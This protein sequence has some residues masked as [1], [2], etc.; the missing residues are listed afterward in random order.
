MPAKSI[1]QQNFMGM[2]LAAKRGATPASPRVAAAA[3]GM[4][5]TQ[6]REFAATKTKGLPGHAVLSALKNRLKKKAKK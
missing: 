4:T 3:K 5:T 2:V 6:A 1:A